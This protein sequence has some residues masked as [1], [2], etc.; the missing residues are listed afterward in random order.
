[1]DKR[2]TFG[3]VF[4]MLVCVGVAFAATY[5]IPQET[6][7]SSKIYYGEAKG[8]EKPA[9]IDYKK[10]YEETPEYKEIKSKKV[11][12]DT[13][14]Y[15]ILNDKANNRVLRAVKAVGDETEYD[16]IA[17][18][19]YLGSLETAIPATDVSKNVIKQMNN[20]DE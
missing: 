2:I 13:G 8:F 16:L 10:I 1:M 18:S 9:E 4:F 12:R 15:W 7:D 20:A 17:E 6:V 11:S 14:R 5:S 19:G 3:T